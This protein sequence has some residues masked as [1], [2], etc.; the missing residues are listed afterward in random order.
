MTQIEQWQQL[1]RRGSSTRRQHFPIERVSKPANW[2]IDFINAWN[3]KTWTE[4]VILQNCMLFDQAFAALNTSLSP[5]IANMLRHFIALFE[6]HLC[7]LPTFSNTMNMS[8]PSTQPPFG[9]SKKFLRKMRQKMPWTSSI[10]LHAEATIIEWETIA[11]HL[12]IQLCAKALV[13]APKAMQT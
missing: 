6:V 5:T 8:F 10:R 9:Q 1:I 3:S 4:N 7:P 12:S 13:R 2:V 11:I